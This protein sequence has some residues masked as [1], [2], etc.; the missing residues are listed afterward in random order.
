MKWARPYSSDLALRLPSVREAKTLLAQLRPCHMQP[1]PDLMVMLCPEKKWL[2]ERFVRPVWGSTAGSC[3]FALPAVR[4]SSTGPLPR[5]K[6]AR[7]QSAEPTDQKTPL[8]LDALDNCA[9]SPCCPSSLAQDRTIH[10]AGNQSTDA[11]WE[12]PTN[13]LTEKL[14]PLRQP[15]LL[16]VSRQTTRGQAVV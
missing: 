9:R 16:G 2:P 15:Q 10:D 1:P 3:L 13:C 12:A 11:T 14:Q 4:A 7:Y 5:R 6:Q 8:L